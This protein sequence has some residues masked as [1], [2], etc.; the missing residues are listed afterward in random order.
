MR[1]YANQKKMDEYLKVLKE[2]TVI[3]EFLGKLSFKKEGKIESE[4]EIEKI[5]VY[6]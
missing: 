4:L 2:R 1:K 6:K 5:F 3:I